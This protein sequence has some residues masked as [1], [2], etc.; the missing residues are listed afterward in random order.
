MALTING[1]IEAIQGDV[2]T[3]KVA[4]GEQVNVLRIRQL[5]NGKQPSV[6]VDIEDGRMISPDQRK[7]IWALIGDYA[8]ATGYSPLEM[9]QWVKACYMAESGRD[10]FSMSSC[11]MSQAAEFLTYVIDFGFEHEL[12]WKTKHMD[13]IPS[14]YPLMMQCLKHRMC[15]ICGKHAEIDHEPPIGRGRNRNDIDN[16]RFKFFPLCHSHH[17]MRHSLGID[18]FCTLFHIKPVKLDEE[19]LI[20]LKLNTRSQFDRYDGKG[21][22]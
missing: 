18:A 10:Y 9:E 4:P 12:P 17:M 22:N 5:A 21:A 13:A 3:V 14:G 8:D 16:R 2:I 6:A 15:V 11:S 19:A 7:K 1:T 20:S